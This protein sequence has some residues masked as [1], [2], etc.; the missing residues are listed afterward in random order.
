MKMARIATKAILI[1]GACVIVPLC[2]NNAQSHTSFTVR[3]PFQS[4]MPEKETFFRNDLILCPFEDRRTGLQIVPF[5]GESTEPEDLARYFLPFDKNCLLAAED[6]AM[7]I[8]YRDLVARNFNIKT[9]R[10]TFKSRVCFEPRQRVIGFGITYKQLLTCNWWIELSGPFVQVEN[11]MGLTEN[12]I[13]NGGGPVNELGLDNSPRVGSMIEA[14]NQP[15]WQFGHITTR[16]LRKRG[17]A[18]IEFK[19]GRTTYICDSETAYMSSFAGF[20]I[21]TG[22]KPQGKFVF[23]PI[24]GHNHHFG[25][26]YGTYMGFELWCYNGHR[27]GLELANNSMYLLPN[28]QVR[29]FDVRNKQWSRYQ[30]LYRNKAQA[31]EAAATQNPNSGTSGINVFTQCVTVRPRFQTDFNSGFLYSY[32]RFLVEAGWNFFARQAEK[33]ELMW[34]RKP[35]IKDIT[36]MGKTNRARTI[37]ENFPGSAL[38]LSEFRFISK[39][40]LLL[41]SAAHPAVLSNILYITIGAHLNTG[42]SII[43]LGLGGSYEFSFINTTLR[44]WLAW[45]KLA[46][47]F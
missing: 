23:E 26:L 24:V 7:D 10:N 22:N 36:G 5:G 21:P 4:V 37:Q 31:E 29:S 44:R 18:D 42:C 9:K 30:E 34:E 19:V 46:V 40:E 35:A 43:I 20:L 38:P 3:P 41:D 12:I 2:A 1:Y 8:M 28:H 17:I 14:F 6:A 33:V 13:D 45:G 15:N 25:F 11:T 32:D 47:S 27:I 16:T 39:S